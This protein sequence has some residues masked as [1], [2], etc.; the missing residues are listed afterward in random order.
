MGLA[1]AGAFLVRAS[2]VNRVRLAARKL[3]EPRYL[4]G[5]AALGLYLAS[6]V[7]RSALRDKPD[8]DLAQMRQAAGV[9]RLG[10]ELVLTLGGGMVVW[11]AWTLGTDRLSFSFTEAEASWLLS[12]PV[13]RRGVVRYKVSVGLLRTLVSALLATLIFR[14]GMASAPVPLV[15]GSWL[16]FSLLWLHGATASLVRVQWKQAGVSLSRRATV[17]TLLLAGFALLATVAVLQAGPVPWLRGPALA[18]Y[19]S[20]SSALAERSQEWVRTLVAEPAMAWALVPAR[21]FAGAVFARSLGQALPSLGVLLL[22][23]VAL[24]AVVL[25][26]N[27]P[28][29]EA[30]LASAERRARLEARRRRRGLPLPRVSGTVRLGAKGRPE[31]ALAWKN[32]LALRRVYGARLGL[33]L[34]MVGV[35]FGSTLWGVFHRGS[36]GTTLRLLGAAFVAGLAA[37]TVLLGPVLFRTDLRSDLRRLDVLRTLPLSG[38]QVVRGELLAPAVLLGATEVALLVLALGLSA[39][40]P[41]QGFP[42]TTRLAWAAGAALLLPAATA[43]VLVVQNAAA[44]V[45]PSLLVNDEESAPRGVEAAGTRLL[46]L[47]ATLLLL[48]LG[49]FPGGVLGLGVGAVAA[50]L[51]LGPL[52]Y[53]LGCGAAAAVLL[54]EVAL[55]LHWMGR[56]LEHLDPTTA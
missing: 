18:T 14:R 56:G 47:G 51:G 17:G 22:L 29:E 46:N 11:S 3:R 15:L 35:G 34:L 54:S 6:L 10:L 48:L 37:T 13:S 28:L 55:A 2:A 19:D 32:W 33:I 43:A 24:L 38:L 52:A 1:R 44:L 25:L 26:L 20:L 36:Q 4:V 8:A 23:D 45:F 5:A 12:G 7:G 27:V 40:T 49:F 42:F 9:L 41:I 39:G 21:A 16:G 31:F 30:A 50:G 53:T